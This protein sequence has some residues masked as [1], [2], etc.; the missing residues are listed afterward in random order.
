MSGRKDSYGDSGDEDGGDWDDWASEE[1][2][3]PVVSLLSD[4]G[5]VV[6]SAAAAWDELEDATGFDYAAWRKAAG[7]D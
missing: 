6:P 7:A 2:D 4:G 5:R 3:A 1:G